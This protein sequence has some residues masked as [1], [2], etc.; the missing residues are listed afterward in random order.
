[1]DLYLDKD[2]S[3]SP[4]RITL[5]RVLSSSVIPGPVDQEGDR[6][7]S[8]EEEGRPK[9][10]SALVLNV[11]SSIPGCDNDNMRQN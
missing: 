3:R 9:T 7:A 1:M 5:M 11:L 4:T 6:G 2:L 8:E 10:S